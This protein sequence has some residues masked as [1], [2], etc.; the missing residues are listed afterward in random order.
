[1]EYNDT[2][3][4]T[5]DSTQDDLVASALAGYKADETG[6]VIVP[7][8]SPAYVA[9]ALKVEQRRRNSNSEYSK[10]RASREKVEAENK[11]LKEQMAKLV[12]PKGLSKEQ[13]DEL[14]ELKF[15][16][17]DKWFERKVALENANSSETNDIVSKAYETASQEANVMYEQNVNQRRE[18]SLDELLQSHNIANPD[19]PLDMNMLNLN[20]PPILVNRFHNGEVD[21]EGFLASVSKYLYASTTVSNESVPS[22]PNL[23][24][25]TG[26][27]APS[28][29]ASE[30]S[31]EQLY[32]GI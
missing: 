6:K 21:A 13:Q 10:E 23:S 24:N 31:L 26:S 29:K 9:T 22:Q 19:K 16:D 1:M 4:T 3:S 12:K 18:K 27:D 14:E 30:M 7:D 15:S 28:E 8:N 11:A 2:Q 5:N 32:S 25:V 20:V 17:P